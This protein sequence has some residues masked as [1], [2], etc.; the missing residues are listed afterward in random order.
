MEYDYSGKVVAITGGSQGIGK[1]M[2][3]A[4]ASHGASVVIFARNA[5]EVQK[6]ASGIS[7]GGLKCEGRQLDVGDHAAV[8]KAFVRLVSERKRLDVLVN[9][10]GIYG[11]IG[12]LEENDLGSW[13][14]A[15]SINLCGTA[16]CTSAV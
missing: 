15:V 12:A 11:P 4:F 7:A 16:F 10:A 3:Q 9:C 8:Q 14:Q 1:A 13:H 2:A 5:E 6:A